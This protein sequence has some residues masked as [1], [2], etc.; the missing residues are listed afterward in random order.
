MEQGKSTNTASRRKPRNVGNTFESID[1]GR[2]PP[3]AVDLEEAVL[4]ALMLE[5][6]AVNEVIDIL[7]P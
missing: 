4:G 1:F 6:E 2:V 7:M 5:K 3:Q